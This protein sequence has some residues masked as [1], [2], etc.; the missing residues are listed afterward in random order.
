VLAFSSRYFSRVVEG[1]VA[2]TIEVQESERLK[3]AESVAKELRELAAKIEH[4]CLDAPCMGV[5][6]PVVR[7]CVDHLTAIAAIHE[8]NAATLKESK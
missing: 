6:F 3:Q 4:A 2:M 5:A 7:N 8:K 1:I